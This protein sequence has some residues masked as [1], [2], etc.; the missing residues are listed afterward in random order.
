M[1]IFTISVILVSFICLCFF[2][3]NFWENRY[4]VLLICGCVALIATLITNFSVRGHLQTKTEILW[5]KPLD[6][7]YLPA[8]L[9]K[10]T[11]ATKR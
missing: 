8:N 4:L 9:F 3:K 2:K 10:D 7:F 1:L 11:T 6:T 5:N